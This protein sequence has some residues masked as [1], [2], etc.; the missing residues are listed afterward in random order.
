MLDGGNLTAAV[1][2]VA[3]ETEGIFGS[4]IDAL[5]GAEES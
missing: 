4:G 2:A 3:A 1:A 5:A